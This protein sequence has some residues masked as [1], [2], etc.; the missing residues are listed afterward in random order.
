MRRSFFDF[1]VFSL[2]F[3][4]GNIRNFPTLKKKWLLLTLKE[5]RLNWLAWKS[6]YSPVLTQSF[7]S[8]MNTCHV[9][10]FFSSLFL[11]CSNGKKISLKEKWWHGNRKMLPKQFK[12]SERNFICNY[13]DSALLRRCGRFKLY[14]AL[15]WNIK[16]Q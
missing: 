16:I 1:D 12:F 8:L 14:Y 10:R 5:S 6:K 2:K 9:L 13:K 3:S 11:I 15:W 4:L 7:L